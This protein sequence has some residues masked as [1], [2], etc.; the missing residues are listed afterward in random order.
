M[1]ELAVV[2]YLSA[3][4]KGLPT[5]P[6]PRPP[7]I[8]AAATPGPAGMT[9]RSAPT[10]PIWPLPPDVTKAAAAA[11][12]GVSKDDFRSAE[13]RIA[14]REKKGAS[15][16]AVC[17]PEELHWLAVFAAEM[18]RLR[19]AQTRG[20]LSAVMGKMLQL[21]RDAAAE[22]GYLAAALNEREKKVLA[23]AEGPSGAMPL[24]KEFW[25]SFEAD[26]GLRLVNIKAQKASRTECYTEE[27]A[28]TF[29]S[30]FD[31]VA[32]EMGFIGM[33]G[34][35]KGKILT[36]GVFRASKFWRWV[37]K[38][39]QQRR[40]WAGDPKY[41]ASCACGG[42]CAVHLRRPLVA[43]G[44]GG[45]SAALFLPRPLTYQPH[46]HPCLPAAL[47]DIIYLDET[48]G[49][50]ASPRRNGYTVLR[51]DGA[52]VQ[53][54]ELNVPVT[55]VISITLGGA[56]LTPTIILPKQENYNLPDPLSTRPGII[57]NQSEKGWMTNNTFCTAMIRLRQQVGH[58]RP[59]LL[60]MDG[61][62]TRTSHTCFTMMAKL[63]I[64][65]LLI[66]PHTSHGLAP[67]DMFNNRLHQ[68]RA[69][70]EAEY[71]SK[72]M[73]ELTTS[74]RLEALVNA[75]DDLA[76][77]NE[78]IRCAWRRAGITSKVRSVKLLANEPRKDVLELPEFAPDAGAADAAAPKPVARED[79][80][81]DATP[82][83]LKQRVRNMKADRAERHDELR[84]KQAGEVVGRLEAWRKSFAELHMQKS[85]LG[86]RIH[87]D[88]LAKGGIATLAAKR[89]SVLR[90]QE[91][92]SRTAAR[93]AQQEPLR[94]AF[95]AAGGGP[96][97]LK[98]AISAFLKAKGQTYI[99]TKDELLG[100]LARVLGVDMPESDEEEDD[101]EAGPAAAAVVTAAAAAGAGAA[102]GR[103]REEPD[104]QPNSAHPTD[105]AAPK[106]QAPSSAAESV[107]L[108]EEYLAEVEHSF[109]AELTPDFELMEALFAEEVAEDLRQTWAERVEQADGAQ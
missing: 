10:R 36:K 27:A 30:T 77:L 109:R 96:R 5:S 83:Q 95:M 3:H 24:S 14:Y 88:L 57:Y 73:T 62:S 9:R 58:Q 31:R 104:E 51:N 39:G 99:G 84:A 38:W 23:R 20:S 18:S 79:S 12:Y 63:N 98:G 33:R 34:A 67:V 71:F 45:P 64:R 75:L 28:K 1:A 49:L 78:E 59:L 17:R 72:G 44:P 68:R 4:S 25:R 43:A 2:A 53:G 32:G 76:F 81:E 50:A 70:H 85:R 93:A 86:A 61:H 6:A 100:L 7:P 22:G 87:G 92:E 101:E 94:Q 40:P 19:M 56:M 46:S 80:V 107:Q 102:A 15:R 97:L 105:E 69:F 66:P 91:Q 89:A 54:H 47:H 41:Y 106:F 13:A 11:A 103:V 37:R 29:L 90:K 82:D 42:M 21:R 26:Y 108:T 55:A 16:R 48:P 8:P 60:V 52:A 35:A 74:M 65:L